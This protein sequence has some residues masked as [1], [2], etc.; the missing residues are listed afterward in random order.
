[1]CIRDSSYVE[2]TFTDEKIAAW[3]ERLKTVFN[4]GFWDG[5]YP[6]SY[7]HLDVYK[8]QSGW[9]GLRGKRMWRVSRLLCR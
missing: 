5:Y 2:G 8:R 1:M 7:T 4:R 6:V 3:D 9:C